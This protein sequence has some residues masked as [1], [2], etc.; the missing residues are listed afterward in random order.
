M[1]FDKLILAVILLV[2]GLSLILDTAEG[3]IQDSQTGTGTS[4]ENISSTGATVVS[5]IPLLFVVTGIALVVGA[6]KLFGT[7]AT[8]SF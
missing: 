4:L 1:A 6:I 5:F 8:K 2:V 3:V 7:L